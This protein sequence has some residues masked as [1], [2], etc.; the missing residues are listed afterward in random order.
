MGFVRRLE[1]I[2]AGASSDMTPIRDFFRQSVATLAQGLGAELNSISESRDFVLGKK[3]F[4]IK[5]GEIPADTVAGQ[6]WRWVGSRNGTALITQETF[7]ITAFDPETG[8]PRRGDLD[9]VQWRVTIEGTPSLRCTLE[10]RYSFVEHAVS[11]EPGFNPSALATAMAAVNAL[12][13]LYSSPGPG[14]PAPHQASNHT[15]W[16]VTIEGELSLRCIF[17]QASTFLDNAPQAHTDPANDLH[18][19]ARDQCHS[20]RVRGGAWHKNLSGLTADDRPVRLMLMI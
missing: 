20:L 19:H 16:C 1:E 7:W 14:W 4:R 13:P 10:P 6:R 5:A 11:T 9:N 17:E 15:Q 2:G 12:L 8:C 18:H 3:S